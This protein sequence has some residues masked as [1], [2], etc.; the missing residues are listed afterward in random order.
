MA[1]C[2]GTDEGEG[3]TTTAGSGGTTADTTVPAPSDEPVELTVWFTQEEGTPSFDRFMAENPNI[4]VN[5]DIIPSDDTFEQL[6]RMQDA[7]EQLPDVIR[8]DGFLKAGLT[9]AGI[10]RPIDDMV[11]LWEEENPESF[12]NTVDSTFGSTVWD[13]QVVGMAYDASM[14]QLYYRADWWAEAGLD[15]P[16]QPATNAELLD[17]L[18]LIKEQRPDAIPW[19]MFG[20]QGEGVNYLFAHMAAAGVPFDGATPDLESDAGLAVIDWY[21]TVIRESLTSDDVI[22]L[23]GDDAVGQFIGG[24][25]AMIIESI[26]LANDLEPVENMEFPDQWQLATLPYENGG[27][28]VANPW[29]FGITTG[30]EHPYEASLILRYLFEP[31]IAIEVSRDNIV[32]QKAVFESDVI[33]ELYPALL[34][35]HIEILAGAEGFPTDINFFEVEDV[36]EQFMQDLLQN[37]DADPAELAARWQEEL[38]AVAP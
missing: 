23:G 6:L 30:S 26:G 8:F 19:A 24:Q 32:R 21:Q 4:T 20:A 7:G 18:R 28:Q 35:E 25:A 36:L 33:P 14:D 11:A 31:D 1:A 9:D 15:V 13:G 12:A 16:W 34:P 10:L 37:P 5:I 38:A 29:T 27:V 2:G 17:A 3:S 22:A